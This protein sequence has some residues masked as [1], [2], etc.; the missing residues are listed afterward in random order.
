MK[1]VEVK[2]LE[3]N[4]QKVQ[5]TLNNLKAKKIF[6]NDILTWFFDFAD[7]S[8]TKGKKILRLRKEPEKTELTLKKVHTEGTIK[9]AEEISVQVSEFNN[10]ITIFES[11]GLSVTD[12][13]KK[14]R[15]SYVLD[16]VH[17]DIDRYLENYD[18]IPEFLEIE[19]DVNLI[20]KYASLLGFSK[21]DC[22][23]WSTTKL[24]N[25]YWQKKVEKK[26]A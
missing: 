17:F 16:D 1:E 11:L 4:S 21:V 2:I 3:I 18:F 8:I 20:Y 6:D 24:I 22:L 25:Y 26:I 12:K 9:V 14:H 5:E 19:G 23:P 15:I 10:M 7:N 13:L